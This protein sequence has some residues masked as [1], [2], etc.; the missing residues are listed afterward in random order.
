MFGAR[1]GGLRETESL[2][3]ELGECFLPPDSDAGKNNEERIETELKETYFRKP[4]SKRVNY[5]KLGINTPFY[6]P[7]KLLLKDWCGQN[8]NDFYLLRDWRL[9]DS[10]QVSVK[11]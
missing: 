1:S 9:L 7:W 10:L 8:V 3:F 4:P 2:A 6:C 11:M 5:L